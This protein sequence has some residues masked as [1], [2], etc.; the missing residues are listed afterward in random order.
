[1]VGVANT[2][3]VPSFKAIKA[4][5]AKATKPLYNSTQVRL[6]TTDR[7]VVDAEEGRDYNR[8]VP[9]AYTSTDGTPTFVDPKIQAKAE[10]QMR[11][12]RC[13]HPGIDLSYSETINGRT[14]LSLCYKF[15]KVR[16][17]HPAVGK[18]IGYKS[19]DDPNPPEPEPEPEPQVAELELAHNLEY[20]NILYE[21]TNI[22]KA[23]NRVTIQPL[24]ASDGV[25]L[26]IDLDT[27]SRLADEYM[28][29][30]QQ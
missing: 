28:R 18:L 3:T 1:M 22:D 25:A 16:G 17:D 26:E 11:N 14:C 24:I 6:T 20:N 27:A 13:P 7:E 21:V 12:R 8:P 2:D 10:R 19:N 23:N 15:K 5:K 29:E 9:V 30:P 4:K